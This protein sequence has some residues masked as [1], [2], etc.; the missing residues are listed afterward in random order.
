MISSATKS[1]VT[2]ETQEGH[3]VQMTAATQSLEYRRLRVLAEMFHDI[4]ETRKA[5]V[6]RAQR[7]EVVSEGYDDVIEALLEMEHKL[8]LLLKRQYR[9]TVS[10]SIRKW[11][12]ESCGIGEHNVARFLGHSG[13]PVWAY[14]KHWEG[15]GKKNSGKDH[16]RSEDHERA[17]LAG[18]DLDGDHSTTDIHLPPVA[19]NEASDGGQPPTEDQQG[20]AV[21]GRHLVSDP[22]YR[23]RVGQWWSF[24]GIGDAKRQRRSGMSADEAMGCGNPTLKS[25]A[26]QLAVSC[27]KQKGHYRDLYDLRRVR[28]AT[29]THND[30]CRRCGPSGRPAPAG[31]P[32]SGKHQDADALRIVAK[33]ITKDL[34]T[35]AWDQ[36]RFEAHT[37]RASGGDQE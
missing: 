27:I 19:I 34:L 12:Q 16:I 9:K 6:S 20:S 25:L 15:R 14:P 18:E 11:Q 26:I 17:V 37:V 2:E 35:A 30:P 1:P 5:Q 7:A 8:S 21:V 33:A 3:E 28:N 22:P 4:Q 24:I 13:D 10:P 32:L 36:T 29:A 31:S 23:R